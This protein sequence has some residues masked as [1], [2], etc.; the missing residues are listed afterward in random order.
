QVSAEAKWLV[1][2]DLDK[3][4]DTEIGRF[5]G[6]ELLDP[7][8][9]K[10]SSDLQKQFGIEM[11]WRKIHAITIYGSD[12]KA[13]PEANAVVL[14]HSSLDVA[15]SLDAVIDTMAKSGK[16]DN[17]LKKFETDQGPLYRIQHDAFGAALPGG[18]FLL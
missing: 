16:A 14:I 11:D 1:H 12:L 13:H 10:P 5:V 9:A 18:L 15:K 8:L 6:R 7:Q 2:L 17:G 3:F 4:R